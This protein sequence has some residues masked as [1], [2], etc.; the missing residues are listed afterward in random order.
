MKMYLT[1]WEMFTRSTRLIT[2]GW[3]SFETDV[4]PAHVNHA[5]HTWPDIRWNFNIYLF[6]MDAEDENSTFAHT[7]SRCFILFL[8][9]FP[10]LLH[11]ISEG[12]TY[13]ITTVLPHLNGECSGKII[14]CCCQVNCVSLSSVF[15]KLDGTMHLRRKLKRFED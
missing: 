13:Y 10:P 3:L 12:N 1:H 6:M 8:C 9:Y 14:N 7:N 11:Y 2:N 15:F 5:L 4:H